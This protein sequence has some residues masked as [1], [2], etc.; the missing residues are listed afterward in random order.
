MNHV[1]LAN[2]VSSVAASC[3]TLSLSYMDYEE[4]LRH[5]LL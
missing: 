3:F 4:A 1:V 5:Y 2:I